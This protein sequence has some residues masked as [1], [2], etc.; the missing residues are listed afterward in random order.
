MLTY[1]LTY[2]LTT[3]RETRKEHLRA[4]EVDQFLQSLRRKRSPALAILAPDLVEL[5]VVQ[6]GVGNRRIASFCERF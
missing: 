5:L 1:T 3:K 2:M 6:V 4:F